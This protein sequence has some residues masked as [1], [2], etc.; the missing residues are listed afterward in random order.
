MVEDFKQLIAVST[1][2]GKK[3]WSGYQY[4]KS[5]I[6]NYWLPHFEFTSGNDLDDAVEIVRMHVWA[7]RANRAIKNQNKKNHVDGRD[8]LQ[9]GKT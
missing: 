2:D 1:L 5:E 3:I 6:M 4:I 9:E 8:D 7:Y